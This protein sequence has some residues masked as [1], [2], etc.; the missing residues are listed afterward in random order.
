VEKLAYDEGGK[1]PTGVQLAKALPPAKRGQIGRYVATL[2][3]LCAHAAKRADARLCH[4]H[5]TEGTYTAHST[6]RR[7]L[8]EVLPQIEHAGEHEEPLWEGRVYSQ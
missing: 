7:T 6:T 3:R 1:P 4:H 5:R 8:R 2:N